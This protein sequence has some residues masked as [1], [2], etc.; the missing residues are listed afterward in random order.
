MKASGELDQLAAK[1]GFAPPPASL[2]DATAESVCAS[3]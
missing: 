3:F 2:A 1:F